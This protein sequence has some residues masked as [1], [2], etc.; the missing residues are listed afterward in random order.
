MVGLVMYSSPGTNV[1]VGPVSGGMSSPTSSTVSCTASVTVNFLPQS[2][3][4][5]LVSLVSCG[6]N[7]VQKSEPYN[8]SSSH[9]MLII[10]LTRQQRA[11]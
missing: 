4:P 3:L 5:A 6:R 8:V 7:E 2:L 1:G 9:S 10:R 11:K